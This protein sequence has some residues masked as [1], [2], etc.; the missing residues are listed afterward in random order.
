MQFLYNPV[1]ILSDIRALGVSIFK[2]TSLLRSLRTLNGCLKG[3]KTDITEAQ[4]NSGSVTLM[5]KYPST[6]CKYQGK[7]FSSIAIR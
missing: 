6:L 4:E 2:I 1:Q 7:S 5:L 3:F